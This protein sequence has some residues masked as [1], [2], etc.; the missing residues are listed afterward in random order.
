MLDAIYGQTSDTVSVLERHRLDGLLGATA[1]HSVRWP[2]A[3]P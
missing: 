1:R 2:T 3:F